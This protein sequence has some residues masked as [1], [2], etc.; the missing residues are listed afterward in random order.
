MRS[1]SQRRRRP[2]GRSAPISSPRQKSAVRTR[3]IKAGGAQ[4]VAALAYGTPECP[5]GRQ[6]RR[7]RQR[8]CR[9]GQKAGIR[10]GRYRYDCRAE[11]NPRHCRRYGYARLR[12]R[13]T[14]SPRQSMTKWPAL[15]SSRQAR[16]WLKKLPLKSSGSS[17]ALPRSEIARVSIDDNGQIIIADS[18]AQAIEISNALAPEHLE[19]CVEKPFELL[20]SVYKC[21]LSLPRTLLP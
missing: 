5:E 3:I 18:L 13:P 16:T 21:R 6:N 20:D 11:R 7:A 9:R 19:L 12:R 1:C 2:T 15:C 10:S 8:L 14:C 17:S 4:A